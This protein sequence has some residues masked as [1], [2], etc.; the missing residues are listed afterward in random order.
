MRF[1]SSALVDYFTLTPYM[2]AASGEA[3]SEKRYYERI[4][5]FFFIFLLLRAYLTIER[6]FKRKNS[7]SERYVRAHL[8]TYNP[9]LPTYL[10]TYLNIRIP[11]YS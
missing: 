5:A 9:H 8:Y 7:H 3:G 2:Q 10:S 4:L 1:P 6:D 11:L